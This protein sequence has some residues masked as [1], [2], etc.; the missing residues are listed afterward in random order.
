[1]TR[2][3]VFKAVQSL[4]EERDL[5][6]ASEYVFGLGD[7][8]KIV[9]AFFNLV[10]DC[11][12]KAKSIDQVLHFG[13]AGIHYC[14]S[15]A[16]VHDDNDA[17]AA[18]NCRVKARWMANNVVSFTWPG[19]NEP[20]VTISPEQMR[21]GLA[22][23]RY[24]VRQLYELELD[25]RQCANTY[26]YLGI[27]LIAHKQYDEALK[28]FEKARDYTKEQGDHPD[29]LTELE[30]QIGLTRILNG[31]K[32]VGEAAFGAAVTALKARDNE[33]AKFYA[34]QLVTTRA[35]FEGK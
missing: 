3:D 29:K 5:F 7:E 30:G 13:H 20:G 18:K 9:D 15:R 10:L 35:V 23:A 25:A 33:D 34:E 1:M 12:W 14:L 21:H 31:E 11:Y 16:A 24:S 2:E 8:S 32:E 4:A 26:W 28:V 17:A 22:F 27:Q 6:A 19:W